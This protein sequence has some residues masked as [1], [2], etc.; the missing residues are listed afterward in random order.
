MYNT[1]MKITPVGD[2]ARFEEA[3]EMLR[4]GATD[5]VG[6]AAHCGLKLT[7]FQMRLKRGGLLDAL[8]HT[9]KPRQPHPEMVKVDEAK[10]AL[11]SDAV[12]A[13]LAGRTTIKAATQ[14]AK[15]A[16]LSEQVL[17]RKVREAEKTRGVAR[18]GRP[19]PFS[20]DVSTPTTSTPK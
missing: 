14:T 6:A 5:R 2:N 8:A 19:K 3:V 18:R 13:V 7:T 16:G 11:Y 10:A 17:G 15:Y 1:P 4:T 20:K 12:E 9:R